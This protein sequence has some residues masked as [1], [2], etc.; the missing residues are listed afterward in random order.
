MARAKENILVK[1]ILFYMLYN[2]SKHILY[3][4]YCTFKVYIWR[5]YYLYSK[6]LLYIQDWFT[7]KHTY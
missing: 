7:G 3:S 2:S 4:I 1:T 6:L 5:Q